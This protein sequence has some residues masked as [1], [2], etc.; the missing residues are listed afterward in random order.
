[1]DHFLANALLLAADTFSALEIDAWMGHAHVTVVRTR[2]ELHGTPGSLCTLLAVGGIA[3]GITTKGLRYPL[4]DED[5]VPGSTRGVSNV[6]VDS[7]GTVIVRRGTVLIVQPHA[8]E[9]TP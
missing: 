5:L 9:E 1:M 6:L 2:A 4:A 8:L 3:H 7:T